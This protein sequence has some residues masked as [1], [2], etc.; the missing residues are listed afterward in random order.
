MSQQNSAVPHS[1]PV[2][3]TA[4][5]AGASLCP[6]HSPYLH[7][8]S[9]DASRLQVVPRAELRHRG[10]IEEI[11]PRWILTVQQ[12]FHQLLALGNVSRA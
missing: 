9:E 1:T 4:H 8:L 5:G 6:N 12:G 11:T 7:E 10:E 3:T 2:S